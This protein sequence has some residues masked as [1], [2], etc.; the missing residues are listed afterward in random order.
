MKNE[1]LGQGNYH[2]QWE[3][4]KQAWF[5]IKDKPQPWNLRFD[6]DHLILS[7]LTSKCNEKEVEFMKMFNNVHKT[8]KIKV[9]VRLITCSI[10]LLI[11]FISGCSNA[12]NEKTED[13]KIEQNKPVE[14]L[15]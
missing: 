15:I 14:L 7:N 4:T 13:S 9:A 2:I 11:L 12:V 10:F 3:I 5:E 1:T 6:P 8:N